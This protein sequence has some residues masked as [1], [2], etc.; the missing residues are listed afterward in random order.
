MNCDQDVKKKKKE[1]L[2]MSFLL[3]N[4][5]LSNIRGQCCSFKLVNILEGYVQHDFKPQL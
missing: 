3:L 1:K 2:N 4:P 5:P